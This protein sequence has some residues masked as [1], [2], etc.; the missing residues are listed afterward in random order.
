MQRIKKNIDNNLLF[1]LW[2]ISPLAVKIPTLPIII[3]VLGVAVVK[4]S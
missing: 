2:Q 1:L 3:L 4:K